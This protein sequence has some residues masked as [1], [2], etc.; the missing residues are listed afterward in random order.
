MASCRARPRSAGLPLSFRACFVRARYLGEMTKETSTLKLKT[1]VL[2]ALAAV[3]LAGSMVAI[4]GPASA[5]PTTVGACGGS[6]SLASFKDAANA[7]TTL[8]DQTQVSITIGT[9]L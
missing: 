3:G 1:R 5:A 4:A 2:G 7:P 6:I 8:T 9:K